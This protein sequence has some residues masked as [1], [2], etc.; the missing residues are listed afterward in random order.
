MK[1][2]LTTV[3]VATSC[4]ATSFGASAETGSLSVTSSSIENNKTI[5]AKYAFCEPDGKGK[6]RHC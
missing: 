2:F 6:T 5:P 3:L 4:L 1:R